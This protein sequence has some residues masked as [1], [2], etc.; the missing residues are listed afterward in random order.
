MKRS[1]S[2]LILKNLELL[3]KHHDC[4]VVI[5]A[6]A[7]SIRLTKL[8]LKTSMSLLA[9]LRAEQGLCEYEN[10]PF[11]LLGVAIQRSSNTSSA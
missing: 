1:M 2:K 9:I 7:S 5:T 3:K 4:C 8:Q 6:E 10:L 11:T